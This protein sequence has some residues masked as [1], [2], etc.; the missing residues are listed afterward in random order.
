METLLITGASSFLGQHVLPLLEDKGLNILKP[1]SSELNLLNN[2][3]VIQYIK[4]NKP[5]TILH[6]AALC[7]GIGANKNR[8]G[9]FILEN[10]K[11]AINLFDAIKLE[12]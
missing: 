10:T 2:S 12:I 5:D 3:D 1:R 7:G 6:M 11:M 4:E 9:D 8:P